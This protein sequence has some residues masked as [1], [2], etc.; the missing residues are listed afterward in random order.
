MEKALQDRVE[1]FSVKMTTRPQEATILTREALEAGHELIISVGGDGTNNEVLNGFFREDG[2]PVNPKGMFSF[3]CSGTGGDLRRSITPAKTVDELANLIA[4]GQTRQIDVGKATFVDLEGK[5]A[6]RY[7]LNIS[8]FG[9][10]GLVDRYVNQSQKRLGGTITFFLASLKAILQYKK[11]TILLTLDDQPPITQRINT[12]AIANGR[13]FGG[14]MM[15]APHAEMDDG[16][17]DIITLGD[18]SRLQMLI[19]GTKI[20]SGSHLSLAHVT[21]TRAKKIEARVDGERDVWLD[22]DGELPGRL[23]AS[24]ELLPK[25]LTIRIL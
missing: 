25:A 5:Q 22:V 17:F 14:G 1:S 15:I 11:P 9:L 18:F 6:Q 12:I 10:S 4:S 23:P 24:F 19:Q 2:S 21:E 16:I 7:F 20:Y 8:S 3:Y 13:F